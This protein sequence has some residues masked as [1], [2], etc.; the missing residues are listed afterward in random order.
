MRK[1]SDVLL[2]LGTGLVKDTVIDYIVLLN[3]PHSTFKLMT[4]EIDS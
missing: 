3:T 1:S 2:P 4:K